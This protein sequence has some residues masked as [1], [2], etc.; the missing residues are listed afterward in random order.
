LKAVT[1]R[2]DDAAERL[3]AGARAARN[4]SAAIYAAKAVLVDRGVA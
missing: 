3:E 1:G 4:S 2:W